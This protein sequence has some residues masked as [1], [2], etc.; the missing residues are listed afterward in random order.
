MSRCEL[1]AGVGTEDLQALAGIAVAASWPD[2]GTIFQAG[3]PADYM[4][5]VTA[6]RIR[7]SLGSAAGRELTIRY[8]EPGAVVGEMGVLD[9]EPRS[10]DA[11]ATQASEGLIIRRSGFEKALE[12]RPALARAVIRSLSRKLR[13]TTYRLESAALYDLSARLARYFLAQLQD[14][15]GGAPPA[16]AALHLSLGQSELAT[17]LGAS[18]PKLNRALID[19]EE[20]GAIRRQGKLIHCDVAGLLT[21]AGG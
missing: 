19:L 6:G 14:D 3:D 16:T 2:G 10:A 1:F 7:L 11:A 12:Q 20:H 5:I 21:I 4:I 18:R 17:L 9:S 15:H 13:Q 8:A